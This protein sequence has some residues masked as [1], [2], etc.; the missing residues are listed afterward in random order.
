MNRFF[1]AGPIGILAVLM[2]CVGFPQARGAEPMDWIVAVV[3]GEPIL[4][5]ELSREIDVVAKRSQLRGGEVYTAE[6]LYPVIL[7]QE[8]DRRLKL[9]RGRLRQI[10]VSEEE[11]SQQIPSML[12]NFGV[13]SI[14]QLQR[15]YGLDEQYLRRVIAQE[16]TISNTRIAE[17]RHKLA[18]Y[19]N[20]LDAALRN[21][22][23]DS[24]ISQYDLAQIQLPPESEQLAAEL[25]KRAS[26][27]E[28]F[29]SLAREHSIA[30]NAAAGGLLG[31]RVPDQLPEEVA[32]I[33]GKL[34]S[35]EISQPTVLGNGI[36]LFKVNAIRPLVPGTELVKD[37]C[38]LQLQLPAELEDE[39]ID[40]LH[41]QLMRGETSLVDLSEQ[42]GYQSSEE[43]YQG[44]ELLPFS[45]RNPE[46]LRQGEFIEP[47]A[48]GDQWMIA[49]VTDVNYAV[50]GGEDLRR[51]AHAQY[52]DV[53]IQ[54]LDVEWT[55]LLRS[56]ADIDILR[57]RL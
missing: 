29:A 9:Q 3:N 16:Q 46:L 47:M 10:R 35:D 57:E 43:C 22:F 14:E 56:Q 55:A 41:D 6:S 44:S 45:L 21:N 54:R 15:E 53:E 4:Y 5:S 8:I 19:G 30:D 17:S 40:D 7:R 18:N 27:G 32:E 11:I 25:R 28:D 33:V 37:F 24:M 26:A 49:L 36:H 51:Q 34:K 20:N 38:L 1:L 12:A 2:I 31:W 42:E 52:Q 13:K 23:A 48:I 50:I 39:Q